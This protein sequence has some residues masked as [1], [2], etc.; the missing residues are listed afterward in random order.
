MTLLFSTHPSPQDR[1]ESLDIAMETDDILDSLDN[2]DLASRFSEHAV[3][4]E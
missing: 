3:V 2:P 4:A 1:L